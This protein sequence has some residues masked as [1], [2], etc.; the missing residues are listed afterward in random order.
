VTAFLTPH[1]IQVD[2]FAFLVG[3]LL[4]FALGTVGIL[5]IF[6]F[7]VVAVRG[8]VFFALPNASSTACLQEDFTGST[9]SYSIS[10][11]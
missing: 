10:S 9:Y 8:F 1:G 7:F 2:A 6:F 4:L 5:F 3:W 11:A